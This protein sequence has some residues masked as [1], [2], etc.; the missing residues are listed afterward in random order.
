VSRTCLHCALARALR[1]EVLAPGGPLRVQLG[2]S[3]PVWLPIEGRTLYRAIRAL[4]REAR[5]EAE[6]VKLAVVDLAGKSH[7]EVTAVV[8]RTDGRSQVL[9]RAFP[10]FDPR[11]LAR[12]FAEAV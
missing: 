3:D 6:D 11:M 7:V 12:G 8:R 5:T 4:L 9:G 1:A 10:R 2:R